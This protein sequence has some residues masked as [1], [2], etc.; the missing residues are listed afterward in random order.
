[1]R[2]GKFSKC[3]SIF[4]LCAFLV[5]VFPS[6]IRTVRA[7]G[8]SGD[9]SAD[10]GSSLLQYKY[11]DYLKEYGSKSKAD[12]EIMIPA[13]QYTKL[14]DNM[15]VEKMDHFLSSQNPVLKMGDEG[16]IEWEFDVPQEGLY[17]IGVK[18]YPVDGKSG[19]A[20]REIW[21]DGKLPFEE[22]RR[23]MFQR[24]WKNETD[25]IHR[26]ARGND[27][28]PR[29]IESPMWQE[30]VIRD[31]EGYYE[32]PYSFY[33]TQGK[34]TLKLV[35]T[36]EPLIIEYIK[37]YQEEEIP[38]Y[39]EVKKEYENNGYK[40]VKEFYVEIQG[41]E[42]DYKSDPTLY[43]INDRSSPAT[44]PYDTSKIRM[45]SIGGVNWKMSGQWLTWEFEVQEDGLYTI[46]LKNRQN[47]SRGLISSR[48]IY[49]DDK[50]PFKEMDNQTFH[51]SSKWN[52]DVLGNE[53]EP[54][55][56]YLTKGKHQIKIEATLGAMA[57]IVREVEASVIRLNDLYR[58]IIMITSTLPDPFRDYTLEEQIP[59]MK[60]TFTEESERLYRIVD[61][62]SS[63]T[64]QKG[65]QTAL[66]QKV[67]YQLKQLAK[68][69]RT[70]TTVNKRLE[71]YKTNIGALGT[72]I[73]EVK[74]QPLEID[75]LVVASQGHKLKRAEA[76]F[77]EKLVHEIK[78]FFLSFVED[79]SFIGSGEDEKSK[80]ITVWMG[81]GRDQAQVMKSMID[82][83]F[84]PQTGINVKLRLID[85]N[86]ILMQA[87][88]AGQAPDVALGIPK[89]TPVNFAIRNAVQDLTAFQNEKDI[90][91]RFRES[92]L[93]SYRFQD[94]LYALP[95]QETYN[96][97]FYRKD[98]LEQLDIEIPQTWQD[99][100]NIIPTLQKKHLEFALPDPMKTAG[101]LAFS[102]FLY[103]MGGSF[104]RDNDRMSD[105]D[106]EQS[107]QAFK[108]W[109]EFYTNYK[110]PKEYDAP[111]RFRRGEIPFVISDFTLY[112]TLSVSAPEIRG[113]WGFT[114]IPG[115]RQ[116][117][118]TIR[119]NTS[120]NSTAC[121]MLKSAKDKDSAWDFMQWWTSKD[122][123][124]R[125][126][127]EMESILGASARYP[128][129]N[130]E[131][132]AEL[133]WPTKDFKILKEQGEWVTGI[134]EVPGGYFTPR[135]IENAFKGVINNGAN[136]RETL[137]DYIDLI[138]EEITLKRHEFGLK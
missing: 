135:H 96:V 2:R 114:M 46:G 15:T 138:N 61:E 113:L 127:R 130:I 137:L 38:T 125:F 71:A 124:V 115:T 50:V 78:N 59:E 119:R 129:A 128:T 44:V 100:Y 23:I 54:F 74:E 94:G 8:N 49:I 108:I 133:P 24:V 53:T 112:N 117:D 56:F 30:T 132:L 16:S 81:G 77:G 25:K 7:E 26:D 87:V 65:S 35:S 41:E 39:A 52:I 70:I 18:Y 88:V 13:I 72:W 22:A 82:D 32:D 104:Y 63:E 6:N 48:R 43:P 68:E 136:P 79:Y 134:P 21:I 106:S 58:K 12:I 95:E 107:M 67:A 110:M 64:K 10:A 29:Q 83:M 40:N 37:L 86:A 28:R 62:L 90:E 89:G 105:L 73:M 118:G 66:L 31:K 98:I 75:Y 131:A 111:S 51:Y 11:S 80:T 85:P 3:V 116:A 109:T 57:D 34:H 126:G 33:F 27:L 55:L 14:E 101:D 42:A 76:N 92:A 99:V 1:M 123:Q 45:N 4:M 93:L 103:Q 20:E 84:T 122:A 120:N 60:P 17:N 47:L 97:M 121:I 91:K 19:A 9:V 5:Q 36:R 69:P 102:T